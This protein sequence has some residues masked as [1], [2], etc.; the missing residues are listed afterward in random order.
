MILEA[1]EEVTSLELVGPFDYLAEKFDGKNVLDKEY[2][3]HYR[4][5]TDLPEF[6]TL[7]IYDKGRFGYWR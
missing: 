3:V 1:F 5:P 7:M 6:Q 4:F 2:L